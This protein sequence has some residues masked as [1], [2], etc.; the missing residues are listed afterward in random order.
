[1]DGPK[2]FSKSL[3]ASQT[4]EQY[5]TDWLMKNDTMAESV[6]ESWLF[7]H[8]QRAKSLYLKYGHFIGLDAPS[9]TSVNVTKSNRMRTYIS[10]PSI[11]NLRKRLPASELRKLEKQQ[12]FVELLK[13]VVSTDVDINHLGHK[14]L[15]NVLLLTKADRSSLFLIEGTE[16]DQVLVSRLFDVTEDTSVRDAI[17]DESEAIKLPMG[18]GIAGT[19]AETGETINLKDAYEVCFFYW[20]FFSV[21][22]FFLAQ[23][24]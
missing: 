5:I 7:A 11:P 16:D 23:L 21:R 12:L 17:H 2:L 9:T 14:I 20:V 3:S 4:D 19:V 1:M 24:V 18:V 8:P 13:D 10:V 6:V 22:K 15:V